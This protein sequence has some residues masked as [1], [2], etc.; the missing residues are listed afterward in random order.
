MWLFLRRRLIMW[1][2]L[3]I[4]VPVVDWLLGKVGEVLRARKGDSAVTRGLD[5]ARSGLRSLRGKRR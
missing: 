4:A 1:V 3:A 5:T 2:V